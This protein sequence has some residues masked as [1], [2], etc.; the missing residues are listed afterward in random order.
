MVWQRVKT[1][2]HEFHYPQA[3]ATARLS[4]HEFA[5]SIRTAKALTRITLISAN[6]QKPG[7]KFEQP[8]NKAT[9]RFFNREPGEIREQDF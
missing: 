2:T 6:F 7:L 5:K 3:A 9:R 1:R 8:R 4:C